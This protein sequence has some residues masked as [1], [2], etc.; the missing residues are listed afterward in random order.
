[1]GEVKEFACFLET[2]PYHLHLTRIWQSGY[3]VERWNAR[4]VGKMA[5]ERSPAGWCHKE[6]FYLIV[7]G[8]R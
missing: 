1:M 2:F 6:L 4:G 8:Q 3:S 5:W 7:Y